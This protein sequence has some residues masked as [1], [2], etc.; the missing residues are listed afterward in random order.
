[1]MIMT[2]VRCLR[3]RPLPVDQSN[4]SF[5]R[6]DEQNI[7]TTLVEI[8]G[9]VKVPYEC[10]IRDCRRSSRAD[11]HPKGLAVGEAV[12]EAMLNAENSNSHDVDNVCVI[13]KLK[14]TQKIE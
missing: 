4:T 6:H 8:R 11:C 3:V 2:S 14:A 5:L 10:G 12:T 7:H 9:S 13:H 1:M